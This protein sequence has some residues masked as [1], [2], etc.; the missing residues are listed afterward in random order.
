MGHLSLIVFPKCVV[1]P[2]FFGGYWGALLIMRTISWKITKKIKISEQMI[3]FGN[4]PEISLSP[5][6]PDE[7]L[8]FVKPS[9][10]KVTCCRCSSAR[11][12]SLSSIHSVCIMLFILSTL[13]QRSHIYLCCALPRVFLL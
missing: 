2:R 9:T 5:P 4:S 6:P 1:M 11:Y 12:I 13:I 10:P 7:H 3:S 8:P